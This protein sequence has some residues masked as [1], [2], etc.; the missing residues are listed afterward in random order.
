MPNTPEAMCALDALDKKVFRI[1]H[2]FV[3]WKFMKIII[4]LMF[5]TTPHSRRKHLK[6]KLQARLRMVDRCIHKTTH[7]QTQEKQNHLLYYTY[8]S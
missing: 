7:T 2:F 5:M 8:S 3:N 4:Q 6:T 1:I